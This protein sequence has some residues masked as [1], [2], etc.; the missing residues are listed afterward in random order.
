MN[1]PQDDPTGLT[2]FSQLMAICLPDFLTGRKFFRNENGRGVPVKSTEDDKRSSEELLIKVL[3][4]GGAQ[5]LRISVEADDSGLI[6]KGTLGTG[7]ARALI[8]LLIS[9]WSAG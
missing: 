3:A 8:A 2:K 4:L 9:V 1:Y 6:A 7:A 5:D